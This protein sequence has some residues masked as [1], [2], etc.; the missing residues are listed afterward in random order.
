MYHPALAQTRDGSTTTS[1]NSAQDS[2]SEKIDSNRLGG[3]EDLSAEITKR[4][5]SHQ[6]KMKQI[7]Q[8]IEILKARMNLLQIEIAKLHAECEL[9]D[10]GVLPG[11]QGRAGGGPRRAESRAPGEGDAS[12]DR[13]PKR[14]PE[15]RTDN[16]DARRSDRVGSPDE[17]IQRELDEV[18]VIPF[19]DGATLDEVIKYIRKST[20]TEELPN[21]IPV[22]VDRRGLSKAEA[23]VD[24]N[25]TLKT[26]DWP[27]RRSLHF[28]LKQVGLT[29]KVEDGLLKIVAE[30]ASQPEKQA[31]PSTKA[32]R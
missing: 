15:A 26:D 17:V 20:R 10:L 28:L 12:A 9:M 22:F 31:E 27:L 11:E 13:D 19:P 23:S 21:G 7:R 24:S 14:P 5:E 3:R 25:V 32:T 8:E 18:V 6:H 29:Y 4:K 16:A 1:R 30:Y 2:N